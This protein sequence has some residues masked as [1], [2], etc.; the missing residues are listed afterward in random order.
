[1]LRQNNIEKLRPNATQIYGWPFKATKD[2]VWPLDHIIFLFAFRQNKLKVFLCSAARSS[3][4]SSNDVNGY[5]RKSLYN[6]DNHRTSRLQQGYIIRKSLYI[7]RTSTPKGTLRSTYVYMLL[8]VGFRAVLV[9]LRYDITRLVAKRIIK[10]P[11]PKN[12]FIRVVIMRTQ[13]KQI[14][15]SPHI[16]IVVY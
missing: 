16:Q 11:L 15:F 12:T 3:S 2:P 4:S 1:M 8:T 14:I 5:I 6:H 7:H 9:L 10:Y 13:Y